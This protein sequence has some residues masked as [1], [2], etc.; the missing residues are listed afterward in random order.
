MICITVLATLLSCMICPREAERLRLNNSG[1]R[2][3]PGGTP[4]VMGIGDV[5]LPMLTTKLLSSRY[6]LNQVRTGPDNPTQFSVC[7]EGFYGPQ[8]QRLN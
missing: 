3:D 5:F 4:Q 7:Q 6:D 1:P 8:N 2:T